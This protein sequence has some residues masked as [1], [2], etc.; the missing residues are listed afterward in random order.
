MSKFT[1]AIAAEPTG[2]AGGC[3]TGK[4]LAKLDGED[5]ED[6]V[7]LLDEVRSGDRTGASVARI[8]KRTGTE[9]KS[10]QVLYHVHGDCKCPKD[11]S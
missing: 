9:I 8:V 10:S 2:R 7:Q 6:F 1:E 5:L 11:L 4:L 3:T